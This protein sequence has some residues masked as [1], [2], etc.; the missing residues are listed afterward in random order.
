MYKNSILFIEEPEAH[1]HPANQIS[2]LKSFVKLSH[3]NVQLI[4]ASHSN[5][6]FNQLNNMVMDQQ[7]DQTS[8]LP[9]L[10]REQNHTT[11]SE[12]MNMDEFGVDDENFADV[13]SQLM[14]E[15]DEIIARILE[16]TEDHPEE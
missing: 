8:Y 9:L 4:M 2:L 10:M 15:R 7:L 5:Y 3:L 11:I 1:L 12:Y 6:L 14:E 13:S 16:K